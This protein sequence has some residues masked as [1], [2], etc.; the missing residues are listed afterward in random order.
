MSVKKVIKMKRDALY[1]H[2]KIICAASA[3]GSKEA[4][5]PLGSCFDLCDDDNRFGTKTW[6]SAESEM[7]RIAFNTLLGKSGYRDTDLDALFA[8]DLLN[9]CVGSAYGLLDFTIPYFGLDFINFMKLVNNFSASSAR[10]S[11]TFLHPQS[12]ITFSQNS[13]RS[14]VVAL[15]FI[16]L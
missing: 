4:Q 13:K 16:N 5:G 2:A 6:E 9:Q 7:Q 3:V 1:L 10:S 14:F 11:A 12:S 8:G 15:L